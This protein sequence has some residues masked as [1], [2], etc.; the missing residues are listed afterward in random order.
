MVRGLGV[1][2]VETGRIRKALCRSDGFM[3]RIFAPSEIEY[4]RS[5]NMNVHSIAGGFAAKEAVA[6]AVGTG[7][8]DFDWVDIRIM[9]DGLGSP[10]VKLCGRAEKV[11]IKNGITGVIV[12]I[13]HCKEYAVATAIA[14][15]GENHEGCNT[16][17][18]EG[19][20]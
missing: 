16:G 6:K 17:A 9:R 20:R 3:K 11:C 8:R 5:R 7:I 19:N 13:S 18:D 12:S 14:V 15:G 4:Y 1:D 2:I 10:V